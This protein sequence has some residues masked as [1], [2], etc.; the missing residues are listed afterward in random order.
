MTVSSSACSGKATIAYRLRIFAAFIAMVFAHCAAAT[1]LFNDSFAN[2]TLSDPLSWVLS[3]GSGS[4]SPCLT[5]ADSADPAQSL[6]IGSIG[7]CDSPAADASGS[8]ALRLTSSLVNQSGMMLYDTPL[9]PRG[10][11]DIT[12]TL[13]EYGGTGADGIS[14]FVK[15]GSN[16]N[17]APG[18]PG[19]ALGYGIYSAYAGSTG[20]P[21]GL[22]GVGFDAYGN[23]SNTNADGAS[24]STSAP[25]QRANS[26][27]VRGPDTSAGQ[28]GTDGYCYLG[29]TVAGSVV[30]TAP[31][32]ASAAKLVKI[33]VEPESVTPPRKIKVYIG[34]PLPSTP[35]LEVDLPAAFI[36][37]QSFKFGFAASTGDETNNHAVWVLDVSSVDPLPQVTVTADTIVATHGSVPAIGYTDAGF[38]GADTFTIAPT[39]VAYTDNTYLT[40]VDNTTPPGTYVTHCSSAAAFG[41]GMAYVDGVLTLRAYSQTIAFGPAP[42]PTYSAGGTFTVSATASSG[43]PVTYT[44]LT[45]AVCMASGSTSNVVTMVAAGTC[46][47]AANQAGDSSYSPAPQVT[48]TI[49]ISSPAP[50]PSPTAAPTPG[51]TASPTPAPTQTATTTV[52]S[53]S[54]ISMVYGESVTFLATVQDG[55]SPTGTVTFYDGV[56]VI[57]SSPLIGGQASLSLTGLGVGKHTI[58]ARYNGDSNNSPST[59]NSVVVTVT[60]QPSPTPVPTASPTPAPTPVPTA[61]PTPAP[62]AQPTPTP[63]PM[64]E[65][66]VLR[67]GDGVV[68]SDP[69]GILCRKQLPSVC[70]AYF[71]AG[72]EV[73]LAESPL[74]D[75][76][77]K[78]W[79]RI[80]PVTK[81]R[82]KI[83]NDLATCKFKLYGSRTIE[84][85]FV[86]KKK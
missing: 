13:A 14:F 6:F 33:L 1:P 19:G 63:I 79:Y 55:A 72:T 30:Y 57:G 2:S 51:P 70:T 36:S 23:F 47:I 24:C 11:L 42:S 77:F 37:A 76:K 48:Q 61:S 69:A 38:I 39:C 46:I 86:T 31:D 28:A 74:E 62:T 81:K 29:G 67:V 85:K 84:S 82:K 32:R 8:G 35:V 22:F 43:L 58:T 21:G 17:T 68:T 34:N 3:Y 40:P 49:T 27:A 80:D 78:R 9:P 20:I 12:F 52:L 54:K 60:I 71:E 41:Y 45:P 5:A 73:T 10:G 18:T 7:G 15:D 75:Y 16:T 56:I 66:N 4:G 25:G 83:C 64:V 65:L 53:A 26:V 59:S 44:S 50:S